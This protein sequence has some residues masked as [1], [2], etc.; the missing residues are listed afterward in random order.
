M[1]PG[2]RLAAAV[3]LSIVLL[4]GGTTGA[5]AYAWH[6]AGSVSIAIHESRP[7]GCDV[8]VELP[9]ALINAAIAL[10]PLPSDVELDTRLHELSPAL[11][12]LAVKLAALPDAVLV[13]ARDAQSTVRVEKSGA[14][15]RIKV[16][17]P[18]ERIEVTVPVASVCQLMRKLEV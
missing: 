17:S 15:L 14:A 3:V 5:A 6:H 16:V 18:Q 13:D 10:F 9:A 4:V 8:D 11:R 12:E 1:R 2:E 7:G